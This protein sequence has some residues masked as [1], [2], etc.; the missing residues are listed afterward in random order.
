MPHCELCER[1]IPNLT[2]HHLIPRSKGKPGQELPIILIC[3]ACHRQ[4]HVLFTN[5]ELARE[6]NT[7]EK[8]KEDPG[9]AR[10]LKWVR[11][12][13]PQRHIRVRR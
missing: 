3:S 1:N 7:P 6:L 13:H 4:L 12:Q 10:F 8:I 2:V 9:M 5:D 11:K